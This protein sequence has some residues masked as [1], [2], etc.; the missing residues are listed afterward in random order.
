MTLQSKFDINDMV[1]FLHEGKYYQGKIFGINYWSSFEGFK[2]D[3]EHVDDEEVFTVNTSENNLF[4]SKEE[5]DVPIFVN[6]QQPIP[7][8][9]PP[10]E[11]PEPSEEETEPSEEVIDENE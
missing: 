3:V 9:E 10:I 4:G 2:Y 8:E 5:I 11:D 1:W 6:Y 7:D